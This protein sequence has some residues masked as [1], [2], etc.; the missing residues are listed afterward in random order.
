M[1]VCIDSLSHSRRTSLFLHFFLSTHEN[2]STSVSL[3]YRCTSLLLAYFRSLIQL[4]MLPKR[5]LSSLCPHILNSAKQSLQVTLVFTEYYEIWLYFHGFIGK[6]HEQNFQ[7]MYELLIIPERK[8]FNKEQNK[9]PVFPFTP[10]RRKRNN[11]ESRMMKRI[12]IRFIITITMRPIREKVTQS[13]SKEYLN[14]EGGNSCKQI[15]KCLR[16]TSLFLSA[17]C[18]YLVVR[19][20]EGSRS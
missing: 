12:M 20:T 10:N 17:T 8:G 4:K 5:A 3:N 19:A 1:L 9:A 7:C 16:R 18:R 13:N 2:Q 15:V 6:I 11:V 14:H